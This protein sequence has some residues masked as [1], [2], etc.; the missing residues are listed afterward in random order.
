M[1][2]GGARGPAGRRLE[3]ESLYVQRRAADGEGSVDIEGLCAERP[4]LR[5]ELLAVHSRWR[6][7]TERLGEAAEGSTEPLDPALAVRLD[8]MEGRQRYRVLDELARGG[9]GTVYRAW[10]ERLRCFVA[11]KISHVSRS[12][13]SG[14]DG[15]TSRRILHRFLDEAQV[16]AQLHHP[17]IVPVF[18][19]GVDEQERPFFTMR[20]VEG[21]GLDT[22]IRL[23]RGGAREWTLERIIEGLVAICD[24]LAYAH[25]RG[26]L[27]RDMKPSN[28][29][30]GRFG[31]VYV[32]DWG[33]ARVIGRAD[34]HAEAIASASVLSLGKTGADRTS[35]VPHPDLTSEGDVVGTAFYMS[36]EQ[37]RGDLESISQRS[38]VYSVGA[39]LYEVIAGH[40]PYA[41]HAE[42]GAR[43]VL[44]AV[45]LG[46]PRPV[47]AVAPEAPEELAAICEKAMA[48]DPADRY[49][50][51]D[52]LA[53]DLRAF[54][55]H[56]VVRA[57][58]TGPA[59]ELRKWF[60]RNRLEA[61][62]GL[63]ALVLVLCSLTAAVLVQSR[64]GRELR[65]RNAALAEASRRAERGEEIARREARVA[66]RAKRVADRAAYAAILAAAQ[67]AARGNRV[68]FAARRL[69][70]APAEL[71]G[72]EWDHVASHLDGSE[73][74]WPPGSVTGEAFTI[75]F[76]PQGRYAAVGYSGGEIA[77]R[78][79]GDGE[80]LTVILAHTGRVL[81]TDFHPG[82]STWVSAGADG[83]V[84]TWG[85][86][87][88][89]RPLAA[90]GFG[91]FCGSARFDP[92]GERIVV[93]CRDGGVRM[94][95]ASSLE[96]LW[97]QRLPDSI[98]WTADFSPDGGAVVFTADDNV[99]RVLDSADGRPLRE[100]QALEAN[101]WWFHRWE[102]LFTRD[103]DRIVHGSH[104]GRVW[105]RDA[106][107]LE[108]LREYTGHEA[109]VWGLALSHD[110]RYAAA[111]SWDRTVRLFDLESGAVRAVGVG[112]RARALDVAF[113]VSDR[114]HSTDY[115]GVVKRWELPGARNHQV[116][117]DCAGATTSLSLSPDGSRLLLAGNDA[118]PLVYDLGS[119]ELL[120]S[121]WTGMPFRHSYMA[122]STAWS[123][124]R[125]A[126]AEDM[127]AVGFADG[128]VRVWNPSDGRMLALL[129]GFSD[130][131]DALGFDLAGERLYG[132]SRAGDVIAFSTEDFTRTASAEQVSGVLAM[133]VHPRSGE[134]FTGD[135]S[136]VLV[137]RDPVTL[138]ERSRMRTN[139]GVIHEIA[140]D[141]E[142]D[143]FALACGDGTV[144][145][146]E[147]DS[148][149]LVHELRGHSEAVH[150]VAFSPD[151]TRLATAGRDMAVKVWEL[152]EGTEVLSLA[153]HSGW[154]WGLAFSPDGET[155]LSASG[156]KTVRLWS[157]GQTR[158]RGT[159]SD[160]GRWRRDPRIDAWFA[161]HGLLDEVETAIARQPGLTERERRGLVRAARL[162]GEDPLELEHLAEHADAP[163]AS[164]LLA[165]AR[166]IRLTPTG[167]R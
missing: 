98:A 7:L 151:G 43:R 33:L 91:A 9:M 97:E 6:W 44:E 70:T 159:P 162:R 155:I 82:G 115:A 132:A 60:E 144:R 119:G 131:V 93:A 120:L 57:H 12:A 106:E 125:D 96:V 45:L 126:P 158:F 41:E 42:G 124:R 112:H 58:R 21:Q 114:L 164:R 30:V 49:A 2:E 34:P 123:P 4:D 113:D 167:P 37:A 90:R 73:F 27:H 129:S 11:M 116:I 143:R 157:R 166:E 99:L 127:V 80:P 29:M 67:A 137:V 147:T 77:L 62:V 141:R 53:D 94:L 148:R 66:A 38:D 31:Q 160:F 92:A 16:M 118:R 110:G 146:W 138:E 87:P 104:D 161:E 78:A 59:V 51:A 35:A 61:W 64:R 50:D 85:A 54:L 121:L 145:V 46:P 150:A 39:L 36:P 13:S 140:F 19:V 32:M 102:A 5:E 65:E 136:G 81:D 128:R 8:A 76:D 152:E 52:D 56:R 156:D 40:R 86:P 71:R 10:D 69:A 134:V 103:G 48:R 109:R 105:V 84:R 17:A 83:F 111:A 89:G 25:S 28:V 15:T 47:H 23:M 153:G 63:A 1:G 72:W 20:L 154:V 133:A 101:D 122:K 139:G 26:V 75:A 79:A 3:A 108:V 100:V 24:A 165:R 130:D 68:D 18:D 117:A 142:G 135:R 163:R 95:D 74:T 55:G 107:T 14:L 88:G 149:A 22:A